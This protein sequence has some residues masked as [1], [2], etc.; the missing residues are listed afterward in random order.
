MYVLAG[1]VE[2]YLIKYALSCSYLDSKNGSRLPM[3]L[4]KAVRNGLKTFNDLTYS[5]TVLPNSP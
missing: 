5:K 4:K 2:G 3:R 1:V